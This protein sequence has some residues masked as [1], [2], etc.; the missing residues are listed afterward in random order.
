MKVAATTASVSASSVLLSKGSLRPAKRRGNGKE[1]SE[2]QGVRSVASSHPSSTLKG[3]RIHRTGWAMAWNVCDGSSTPRG[4]RTDRT[5]GQPRE[6]DEGGFGCGGNGIGPF[7]SAPA[8]SLF[9]F[10]LPFPH[11]YSSP[12]PS[13]PFLR[14]SGGRLDG[15]VCDARAER[16]RINKNPAASTLG[17]DAVPVCDAR[18]RSEIARCRRA[19]LFPGGDD[20]RHVAVLDERAVKLQHGRSVDWCHAVS[21]VRRRLHLRCEQS[22]H[23]PDSQATPAKLVAV[24]TVPGPRALAEVGPVDSTRCSRAAPHRGEESLIQAQIRLIRQLRTFIV[25]R[26][27][28]SWFRVTH[29]S[30]A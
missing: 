14:G 28:R 12:C 7:P 13:I 10:P 23:G 2:I 6:R 11:V 17:H 19:R 5:R 22:L 29:R 3:A 16:G 15:L 30:S 18:E 20:D 27:A 4:Q 24:P 21:S 9:P 25:I 8:L 1:S 26:P